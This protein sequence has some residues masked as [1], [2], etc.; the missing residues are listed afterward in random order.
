MIIKSY[1]SHHAHYEL[2]HGVM[3]KSGILPTLQGLTCQLVLQNHMKGAKV[4][5][6]TTSRMLAISGLS[7]ID[8]PTCLQYIIIFI[9]T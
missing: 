6:E 2:V 4:S 8:P 3:S 5:F 7:E 9:V 1:H